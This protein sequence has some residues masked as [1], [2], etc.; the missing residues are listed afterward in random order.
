MFGNEREP[1]LGENQALSILAASIAS[2]A[3]DE[4]CTDFMAPIGM[5]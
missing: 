3:S 4:K 2:P 1:A 5:L